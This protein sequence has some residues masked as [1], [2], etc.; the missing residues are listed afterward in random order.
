MLRAPTI[1]CA[2]SSIQKGTPLK[3]LPNQEAIECLA[4]NIP[5]VHRDFDAKAF[6][7]CALPDIKSLELM[8]RGQYIAQA[9]HE[10]LSGNYS[11]AIA[12]ILESLTPAHTEVEEFGLAGSFYLPHSF[13][14]SDYEQEHKYNNGKD[15]F[16]VSLGALHALTTRF[17]SEFAIRRFLI[18][19]QERTL[20]KVPGVNYVGGSRQLRRRVGPPPPC[21]GRGVGRGV[22][23]R[24]LAGN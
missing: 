6:C 12:I 5:Y 2:P 7:E 4:K 17:T 24:R 23:R 8:Q 1:P 21:H 15:P 19:R 13:F 16:E 3:I 9:L 10:F 11:E 18:H 20:S 22:D 14:I